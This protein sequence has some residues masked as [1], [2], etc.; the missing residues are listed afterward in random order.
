MPVQG[1]DGHLPRRITNGETDTTIVS[2]VL[3]GKR[4]IE[5]GNVSAEIREVSIF[6]DFSQC[7][8]L[9]L[10]EKISIGNVRL[11]DLTPWTNIIKNDEA[12]AF[13]FRK[14]D[15]CLIGLKHELVKIYC[16]TFSANVLGVN[17]LGT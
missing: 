11:N 14:S 13:E 5:A 17:R 10:I 8:A 1:I 12:E 6:G 2:C 16:Q 4:F 7:G 9:F 3:L 15:G